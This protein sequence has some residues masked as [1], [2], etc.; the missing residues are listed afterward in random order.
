L[1]ALVE[2]IDSYA[3]AHRLTRSEAART[4]LTHKP[5][6]AINVDQRIRISIQNI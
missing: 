6:M 3:D 5:V 4:P 1:D 2:R